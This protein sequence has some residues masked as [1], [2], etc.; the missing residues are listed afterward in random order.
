MGLRLAKQHGEPD[1]MV[2]SPAVRALKTARIMARRLDYP[3]RRI[4][5]NSRL[6]ACSPQDL[7]REIRGLNDAM[8]T[9]MLFGHNPEITTLARRLGAGVTAM[10]T[11]AVARLAFDI[12][13]WATIGT[14]APIETDVDYPRRGRK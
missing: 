9:V 1:L 10:P 7:L 14:S 12:E 8:R 11:C 5:R 6:Y 13:S 3:R 2:S 4:Q